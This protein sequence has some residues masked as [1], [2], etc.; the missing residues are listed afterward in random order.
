MII[1]FIINIVLISISDNK[2]GYD[3]NKNLKGVKGKYTN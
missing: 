1:F 2:G 3:N